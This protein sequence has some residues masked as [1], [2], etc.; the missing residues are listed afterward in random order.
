MKLA[1]REQQILRI[2][3]QS[4]QPEL[5]AELEAT[6]QR[7]VVG[8]TKAT[9]E[10]ALVEKLQAER[11]SKRVQWQGVRAISLG[12]LTPSMAELINS[13]YPNLGGATQ[14]ANGKSCTAINGVLTVYLTLLCVC[15]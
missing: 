6:L 11:A 15:M 3:S 7:E 4:F 8:V 10:A 13:R 1:E 9:I 5:P 2:K 12:G 14:N